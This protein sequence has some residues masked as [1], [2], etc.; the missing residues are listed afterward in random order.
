M[1][2]AF[3]RLMLL[4][5]LLAA[6]PLGAVSQARGADQPNFIVVFCDDLG[7]GDIGCFGSTKHRTPNIDRMAREGMRLTSFYSTSGVCTP[8]RSSL[9]TACYPRRVNMHVD[10]K[11]GWVLFPVGLKGLNPKETTVAEV[12]KAAGYATAIIGKWHLGD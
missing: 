2:I 9:M 6:S 3:I 5:A 7:Y 11:G 4:I 1:R 12:L 10:G 8:S